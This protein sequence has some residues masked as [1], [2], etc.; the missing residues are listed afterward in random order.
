MTCL[1][2]LRRKLAKVLQWLAHWVDPLHMAAEKDAVGHG[3]GDKKVFIIGYNKTGTTSL[4]WL[5]QNWGFS[6]GD[7]AVGHILTEDWLV[8]GRTDRILGYVETAQV[9]QDKPFSTD[10]LY[11]VL[12][13]A[14]P[15]AVFILSVRASDQEW[16]D[17]WIRHHK[18]RY[19]GDPKRLPTMD[20]LKRFSN[21]LYKGYFF[22]SD[23]MQWGEENIYNEE[24]YKAGYNR[25]I[26][27]VRAHFEGRPGKLLEI[28]LSRPGEFNR[29]KAFL[30]VKSQENK[31]PHA[32]RGQIRNID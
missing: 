32:N 12:D 6:I 10:G 19:S 18:N 28:C 17:S 23:A 8:H 21:W 1:L 29:L 22:D 9:F 5:F 24:V 7:E 20:E 30:R 27:E 3:L 25:H 14:Y 15:D 4:K 16:F 11:K 2:F 31:F 13:E 26:A